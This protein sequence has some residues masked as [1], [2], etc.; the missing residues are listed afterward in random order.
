MFWKLI[1]NGDITGLV[2]VIEEVKS[3]SECLFKRVK[4]IMRKF[5][6]W[7]SSLVQPIEKTKEKA[8][9]RQKARNAEI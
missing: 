4:S 8:D 2:G 7:I 6:L 5:S 9:N 1:S 3:G